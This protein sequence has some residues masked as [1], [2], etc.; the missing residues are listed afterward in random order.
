M[1]RR[2]GNGRAP[3]GSCR[4]PGSSVWREGREKEGLAWCRNERV[5]DVKMVKT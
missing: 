4:S 3:R 5:D 2:D 1:R